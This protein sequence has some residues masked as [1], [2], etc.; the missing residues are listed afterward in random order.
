MN[1]ISYI[2]Q[3]CCILNNSIAANIAF[4]VLTIKLTTS[5][6]PIV[7]ALHVLMNIFKL[8]QIHTTNILDNGTNLSGG[9]I[10]R[11]GIADLSI[12]MAILLL[13]MSLQVPWTKAL[14]K[15]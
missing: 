6:W 9:Q 8:Y 7:L 15:R 12:L 13:W 10:Q 14:K 11:I 2:P 5:G 4:G 1:S 3:F